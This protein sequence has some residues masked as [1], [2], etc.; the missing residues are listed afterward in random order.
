M[1]MRHCRRGDP[2]EYSK[3]LSSITAADYLVNGRFDN[4][5]RAGNS[6]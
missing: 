3:D 2:I 1:W 6:G 5:C 4:R